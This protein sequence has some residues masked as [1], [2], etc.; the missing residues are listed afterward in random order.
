MADLIPLASARSAGTTIDF[1][2]ETYTVREL[3][4]DSFEGVDVAFFCASGTAS[5][6]YAEAAKKA[7][8]LVVD[9][10]S[11]FRMADG[12]P[13][14]VPEVNAEAARE[15]GG[16]IANPNCS[17]ILLAVA[18]WPLHRAF[19]VRRVVVSTYQAVSGAGAAGLEELERQTKQAAAGEPVTK[20][21]FAHQCV[22]NVFSHDS[23]VDAETGRNVEEQKMLDET[24]KIFG[25]T[26]IGVSATC[27]RVP[28]PRTH[29]ES[30]N[31]EFARE[32]SPEHAREVLCAAPG[33]R[34]V[35][36]R[37]GNHF[38]MPVEASDQDA[39]LIG[40]LRRDPSRA[41]GRGIDLFLAG[42]QIRKGAAT[43]AVQIAELFL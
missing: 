10:S 38:P 36:D 20:Q 33:V 23:D 31:I 29:C 13:L 14:V 27:V 35:D 1:R 22:F 41:D 30:V 5:K 42:D 24:A 15:H 34:I 37:A 39:V 21:A 19:G 6:R 12:V 2:G 18:L 11:A 4:D 7:G 9:N 43:N 17:T 3:G 28:V 26:E 40:R 16:L 25:T 32:V 8:C